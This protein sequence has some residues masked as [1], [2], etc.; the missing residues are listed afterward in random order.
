MCGNIMPIPLEMAHWHKR[1]LKGF[2]PLESMRNSET[3]PFRAKV[4]NFTVP[5]YCEPQS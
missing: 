3:R 2:L 5:F 4:N 1:K